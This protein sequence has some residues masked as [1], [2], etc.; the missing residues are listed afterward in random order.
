MTLRGALAVALIVAED[1]RLLLQLRDNRPDVVNGGRWG[2]FGGHLEPG[3][4]PEQ[5]LL[6]ELD[7]ELDW[8]P[9]HFELYRTRDVADGER[10]VRSHAFAAHLD[11]PLEALTQREGE[12]MALFAPDATPTNAVN[13]VTEFIREFAGSRVYPRMRR[14]WPRITAT[15]LLV[16]AHGRFLLQHRDDKPDIVNPGK[17]GS[18]GGEI[19]PYE[20]PEHGFLRELDEE[21]GWRPSRYELLHAYPLEHVEPPTLV[22]VYAALVD[23]PESALRLGEGQGM[24]F[25]AATALPAHTVPEFRSLIEW[26]AGAGRHLALMERGDA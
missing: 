8:R 15:A 20:T 23:V 2:F 1:G 9:R 19:E 14:A 26:Y 25:F 11:V 13:G 12:A 6:R 10:R 4:S 17:W 21:L 3:E 16:D 7:E 24:G 18:F 22:Y 5:A